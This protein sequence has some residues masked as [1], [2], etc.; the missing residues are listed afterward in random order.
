MRGKFNHYRGHGQRYKL[1]NRT[2]SLSK[3][4][5]RYSYLSLSRTEYWILFC[6]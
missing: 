3:H 1:L 6:L 4:I 2:H 5:M